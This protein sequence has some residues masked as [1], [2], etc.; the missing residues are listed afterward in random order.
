MWGV[1]LVCWCEYSR[2]QKTPVL[3]GVLVVFLYVGILHTAEIFIWRI[4][5]LYHPS[6]SN[7]LYIRRT[8]NRPYV[9][10][11]KVRISV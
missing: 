5:Y 6:I 10:R 1:S 4:Q 3:Q 11:V 7:T 2:E 9:L 8:N